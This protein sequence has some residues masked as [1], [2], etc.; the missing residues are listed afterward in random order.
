VV[1]VAPVGPVVLAVLVVAVALENQ[2]AQVVPENQAVPELVPVG[3]ARG[4]VQV[5]AELEHARAGVEQE[6]VLAEA[7]QERV[8]AEAEQEHGPVAVPPRTKS[9]IA[10]HHRGLPPLLAAVVDLVA[11]AQTMREQAAAEAVIAWEV[12]D[13]VAVAAAAVVVAEDFMVA[14]VAV[15]VAEDAVAEDAAEAEDAEDKGR[16][17]DEETNENKNKYYDFAENFSGRFCGPYFLFVNDRSARCAIGQNRCPCDI[18]A[19][20]KTIRHTKAGSRRP[21][22]GSSEFRCRRRKGDSGPGRRG[23][24]CFRG[25]RSRQEPGGRVCSQGKGKELG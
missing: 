6:R 14:E 9:V 1:L 10:V 13:I 11:V 19:S 12:A 20:P 22:S 21:Y 4:L 25:S 18:A 3:A 8:L 5:E 24:H 23:S 2:A 15:A 7:E 16:V 17:N